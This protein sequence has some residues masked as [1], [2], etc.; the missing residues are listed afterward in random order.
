MFSPF[1]P[2]IMVIDGHLIKYIV[3]PN[4]PYPFKATH[5][6]IFGRWLNPMTNEKRYKET[7]QLFADKGYRHH[8]IQSLTVF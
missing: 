3:C 2:Q 5:F 7:N 6:I 4:Y 1:D 8:N